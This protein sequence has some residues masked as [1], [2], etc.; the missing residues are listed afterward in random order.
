MSWGLSRPLC[1]LFS[2]L[3]FSYVVFALV[4]T[5]LA[6]IVHF[7][8]F[9]NPR[10]QRLVKPFVPVAAL[11]AV[12]GIVF[13][14]SGCCFWKHLHLNHRSHYAPHFWWSLAGYFQQCSFC[15]S[16]MRFS[17]NLRLDA[18]LSS[19]RSDNFETTGTHLSSD[20]V[21]VVAAS[22]VCL[23]VPALYVLFWG[24]QPA[25]HMF[26]RFWNFLVSRWKRSDA[27]RSTSHSPVPYRW[28]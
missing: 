25:V 27:R 15:H 24:L 28:A 11:A 21:A 16:L 3:L 5:M 6:V 10:Q 20:Q 22:L 18:L 17:L 13:G 4:S 19:A 12:V 8:P 7:R 1:N 23:G 26:S 9:A 2:S 14:C